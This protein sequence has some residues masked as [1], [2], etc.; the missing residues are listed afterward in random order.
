MSAATIINTMIVSLGM[1]SVIDSDY[2]TRQHM[3]VETRGSITIL[4]RWRI[5]SG[6]SQKHG[7]VVEDTYNI[8]PAGE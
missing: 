2:T 4:M 3:N 1:V 7:Y 8:H 5:P 6:A